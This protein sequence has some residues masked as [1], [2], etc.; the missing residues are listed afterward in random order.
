MKQTPIITPARKAMLELIKSKSNSNQSE[1]KGKSSS[2]TNSNSSS[3]DDEP[4]NKK[5]RRFTLKTFVKV[6]LKEN[7]TKCDYLLILFVLVVKWF[8]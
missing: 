8:S 4:K 3:S 6:S 5:K 2:A 7:Y 1:R